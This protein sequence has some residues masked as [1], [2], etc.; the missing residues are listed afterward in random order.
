MDKEKGLVLEIGGQKQKGT[1]VDIKGGAKEYRGT[2]ELT[3]G[4]T[5]ELRTIITQIFRLE[6]TDEVGLPTYAV[7][8]NNLLTTLK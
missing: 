1:P 6:R 5:I 3:D 8:S 2:F 4:H 7:R